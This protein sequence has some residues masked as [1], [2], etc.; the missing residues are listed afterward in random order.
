MCTYFIHP[1]ECSIK[2][3]AM[4]TIF[5]ENICFHDNQITHIYKMIMLHILL[6]DISLES[7]IPQHYGNVN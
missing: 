2:L 1:L 3:I 5:A 4:E 6:Q 7:P